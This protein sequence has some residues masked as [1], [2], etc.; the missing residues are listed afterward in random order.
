MGAETVTALAYDPFS[1]AVME[2]PLPFYKALR[3]DHP[4]FY[5]EKYDAYFF[6][7]FD[8]VLELLSYVDNTFLQ[9]EG[10]IP[11]PRDLVVHND[12]A[13]TPMTMEPFPG[14]AHMMMPVHGDLRQAHIKPMMPRAV[15]RLR[16]FVRELADQRLDALLPT[17]RFN[18]TRDYGGLVSASVMMKL[19]GMPLEDA[20]RWLDLINSGTGV[21]PELG[22]FNGIPQARQVAELVIPWIEK[23]MEAG[24]DGSTP[25]VDGMINYRFEGK[26]LTPAQV[27]RA[28]ICAFIGGIET[29]PKIVAHG[30]MELNNRPEQMAAVRAD[31][32]ANV[33]KAAEEMIRYCAPAQWF[34]RTAHR[35]VTVAGQKIRPGQRAFYLVASALRDEREFDNPD[36]FQWDRPIPR[37]LSFGHGVHYCIGA[38]L[39]RMEVQVLVEAFMQRVPTFSFDMKSAIRPP[40]NFQWA[41]TQLPVL[42][43]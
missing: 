36:E 28:L 24:A 12:R 22:G 27:G 3:R 26:P 17:K 21:D 31:L 8:D 9:S 23:R 18:L 14:G 15:A 13:P 1:P 7:R 37:V 34:M 41:W 43:P 32:E 40:T 2:N 30:L 29:A 16:S 6:S 35:E 4:V 10:P 19:M 38:H 42:I 5:S 11:L 20:E 39:A 25:M 33:P